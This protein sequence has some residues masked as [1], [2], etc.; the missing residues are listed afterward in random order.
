MIFETLEDRLWVQPRITNL[1]NGWY[2]R[3]NRSYNSTMHRNFWFKNAWH[4]PHIA[5]MEPSKIGV[6]VLNLIGDTVENREWLAKSGYRTRD[7]NHALSDTPNIDVSF[8]TYTTRF[9][10]HIRF[11]QTRGT[12]MGPFVLWVKGKKGFEWS[13]SYEATADRIASQYGARKRINDRIGGRWD[14]AVYDSLEGRVRLPITHIRDMLVSQSLLPERMTHL[15][16]LSDEE[17]GRVIR[18]NAKILLS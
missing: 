14:G 8:G 6:R 13:P 17:L 4:A 16:Y 2:V 11:I 10:E 3:V 5:E 18:A 15:C 1:S 9:S 12:E 7:T